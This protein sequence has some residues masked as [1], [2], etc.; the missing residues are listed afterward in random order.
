MTERKQVE[1][2]LKDA[3]QELKDT[4]VQLVQAGKLA[5]MGEMAAGVAHEI[6]QPLFGIKGFAT[7]LL[8]DA[9]RQQSNAECGMQIAELKSEIPPRAVNDLEVILQQTDRMT[10]IVNMVR[11]FARA[12]GTEKVL[13]CVNKPLED[14]LMLFSEQLRI[15][16]I[17]VEE[18]LARDLPQVIGNAN[19]LQQVFINLITNARDAMDVKG[20]KGRLK[21]GTRKSTNGICIEIE[22]TGIGADAETVSRMFEP[23][24]TTKTE[25]KGMG[26]GLSIVNRIIMEQG[27]RIDVQCAPGEGCKFSICLPF[28]VDEKEGETAKKRR[29]G[30]T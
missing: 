25:G 30:M 18:N 17:V 12:A 9:K 3:Y 6:T 21:I 2:Q 11:D 16:N 23:F 19:Q 4:H 5:A 10:K 24:F 7:A 15:H 1:E 28:G 27:G 26:L 29:E 22:D 20:G 14:A 8:E 13:L